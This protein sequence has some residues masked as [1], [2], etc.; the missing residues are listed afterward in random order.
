MAITITICQSGIAC[1]RC[2]S[3]YLSCIEQRFFVF[4]I[5]VRRPTFEL[6]AE[7]LQL[8][9]LLLQ[10]ALILLFQIRSRSGMHFLPAGSERDTKEGQ[11]ASVNGPACRGTRSSIPLLVPRADHI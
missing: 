3:S 11:V 1:A 8:F 7:A 10:I 6:V 5:V 4:D 9:D 2:G